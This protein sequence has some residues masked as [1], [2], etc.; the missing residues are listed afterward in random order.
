MSGHDALSV[1]LTFWNHPADSSSIAS[2]L[3]TDYGGREREEAIMSFADRKGMWTYAT[4]GNLA[5]LQT[6]IDHGVPVIVQLVDEAGFRGT[7]RYAIV[8]AYDE[9]EKRVLCHEGRGRPRVY[10]YADFMTRWTPVRSWMLLV[11]PPSRLSWDMTPAELSTRAR[12]YESRN[13]LDLALGDLTAAMIADPA[14]SRICVNVANLFRKRGEFD[15]AEGMYRRAIDLNPSEGQAYNNLAFLLAEQGREL[16]DAE[17][18]A[19]EA[20]LL[21]PT[22]PVSLDTMGFILL[23]QGR[24]DEAVAHLEQARSR[25]RVL[26]GPKQREIAIH[27]ARAYAESGRRADAESVLQELRAADPSLAIPEDLRGVLSLP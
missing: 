12:F 10:A 20:L 23:R 14:N 1:V 15:K 26:P 2:A 4:Y 17:Q 13:Q 18:L 9:Q 16:V 5:T 11:A 22:N 24:F 7:R 21:E 25:A 8:V 3:A 19:Q 6:R 27:L